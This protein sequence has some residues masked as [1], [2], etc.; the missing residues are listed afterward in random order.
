[1]PNWPDPRDDRTSASRHTSEATPEPGPDASLADLLDA[2]HRHVLLLAAARAG[3]R[4]LPPDQV[5]HHALAALTIAHAVIDD[6]GTERWPIISDALTHGATP[7]EVG[8]VTGGL[9]PDELA[10]GL[11][12]WAN[13]AEQRRS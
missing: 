4:P 12:A 2:Y 1:M 6:L 9:E 10:A 3:R 8:A 11:T 7:A 5:V 13:R